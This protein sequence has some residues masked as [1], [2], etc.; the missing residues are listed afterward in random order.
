M[1]ILF[2]GICLFPDTH[3]AQT[4]QVENLDCGLI[5]ILQNE[6]YLISWRLLGNEAYDTGFN[7]YRDGDKVNYE[8][9][10]GATMVLDEDGTDDP[11]YTIRAVMDGEEQPASKPARL[12]RNLEGKNAAYFDISLNRPQEGPGG[13]TYSPNDVSAG[14]LTG[15]GEYELIVKWDPSNSKDN[16]QQGHTDDVI[17]DA[18]TLY[19]DMLWRIYLGPNIRAGA[20]YTQFMVYDFDGNGK[21]ELMLKTAP[22]TKDGSGNY[23]SKGPASSADH[24]ID[25]RNNDGYILEGPEF[26]T[27]FDGETGLELATTDYV[28]D[29]G[30]V[31]SWGDD[32]GNR[33]DRFLAGVAYIDGERPSAIFARGYYTRM[34]V[35]AWD[36]RDGELTQRW[37]FDTDDPEYDDSWEGQGNH[38]FSVTD[39]DNDGKHE[40]IYGSVVIDD[41]GQGLHTIGMGHGD[42]LHVTQMFKDDPI[43]K[44]FMPH[45]W[46]QYGVSLRNADDGSMLFSYDQSGDVGRGVAAEIDS[47]MPGF[48][49]WAS[50]GMGLYDINGDVVGDIPRSINHL[51][52]WDG[53]LSRELLNSNSVTKWDISENSGT[54]LLVGE[55]TSSINGTKANPNLQA[56][57]VGDWREEVILRTDDNS[58]LRV[59]T[60]TMPTDHR[61][62]TFMHDTVYRTSIAWQN[63][64]YNQPPHPGFYMAS[65]MD[66]PLNRP[67]VEITQS[68]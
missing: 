15:N 3:Q 51:V 53:D 48:K 43:P 68:D 56:D 28:P 60:T 12:I 25:Y 64:A 13:K 19:G 36:W 24:S 49:F 33:V 47:D 31:N 67:D 61:L 41:D 35:S 59:F 50:S 52:W 62:Y 32:Y 23:L 57:I 9:I 2:T 30:N 6:G 29:R 55:G 66:F 16:S 26:L 58:S 37:V 11:K 34:V 7:V 20:H 4:K 42:A 22:G 46:D 5:A 18:Y 63:T 39:A 45:E 10:T 1:L 44:I 65:D 54:N 21:S 8:P 27:V 40:I 14:D 17:L 38:Q